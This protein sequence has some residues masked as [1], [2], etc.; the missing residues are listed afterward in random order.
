MLTY[1]P[2]ATFHVQFYTD[3][4]I[5]ADLILLAQSWN[6][7]P[8]YGKA[9]SLWESL[10]IALLEREDAHTFD[11]TSDA[12]GVLDAHQFNT[13]RTGPRAHRTDCG[14]ARSQREYGDGPPSTPDD[15]LPAAQ[16]AGRKPRGPLTWEQKLRV[17]SGLPLEP[18]PD[19]IAS[20]AERKTWLA[21]DPEI[22]AYLIIREGEE[23]LSKHFPSGVTSETLALAH[24]RVAEKRA[25]ALAIAT[26]A[27]VPYNSATATDEEQAL[28]VPLAPAIKPPRDDAVADD[29][30]NA[31][32]PPEPTDTLA[33]ASDPARDLLLRIVNASNQER[34]P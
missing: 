14:T 11:D 18:T 12:L 21:A 9:R 23:S 4:R 31:I 6:L 20:D 19:E 27:P 32:S 2:R 17:E 8:S 13:D 29:P 30:R 16:R 15:L 24:T 34:Q 7:P 10:A 26:Q 33:D 5:V 25:A 22:I 28:H 1:K 3:P